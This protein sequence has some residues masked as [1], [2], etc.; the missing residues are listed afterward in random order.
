MPLLLKRYYEREK[1]PERE[2]DD[3]K[4]YAVGDLKGQV[5]L[6]TL[7]RA[8]KVPFN[9]PSPT[10]CAKATPLCGLIGEIRAPL[11]TML[12]LTRIGSED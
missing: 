11:R 10:Q 12:C 8:S 1:D 3:R 4:S 9:M 5:G 7:D 6:A 2:I